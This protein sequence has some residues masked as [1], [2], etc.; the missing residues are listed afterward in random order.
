MRR[1]LRRGTPKPTP[2]LQLH[3][4]L[5]LT[6]TPTRPLWLAQWPHILLTPTLTTPWC[7]PPPLAAR[8][9]LDPLFPAPTAPSPPPSWRRRW[10]RGRLRPT[11]R[12]TG[13]ETTTTLMPTTPT[14]TPMPTPTT[15]PTTTPSAGAVTTTEPWFPA[16]RRHVMDIVLDDTL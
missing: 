2:I 10:R 5:T 15:P 6:P 9:T 14:I 1:V 12:L 16:P 11:P 13:M 7:T 3:P 4:L 8:T